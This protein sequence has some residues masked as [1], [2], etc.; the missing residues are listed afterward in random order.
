M[1]K[2]DGKVD[3]KMT[4][5]DFLSVGTRVAL[6]AGALTLGGGAF[7]KARTTDLRWQLN[8]DKCIQCGR[9][10]INCVLLPSAV[11][12]VHA[13]E[14][15]GYCQLC[16]GFYK[17]N[18][19]VLDTAGENKLCPVSAIK[20]TFVEDPYYQYTIDTSLC[21][22]CGKCVK[23]CQSFGNGSL[24]LQV[25]HD[26]CVNCNECAIARACPAKAYSRVPATSPYLLKGKKR[27][28][29]NAG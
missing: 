29:G 3:T 24:F 25:M 4:R 5:R 2:K 8:P 10:S 20:R 7:F 15:C 1:K 28:A 27:E 13:F 22:G 6:A 14:I 18:A 16:S 21:I 23:G 9:C 19:L 17:P 26:R 11:K 12:V